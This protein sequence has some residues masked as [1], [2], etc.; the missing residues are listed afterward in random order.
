MNNKCI[1]IKVFKM[2]FLLII[3][4]ITTVVTYKVRLIE[5]CFILKCELVLYKHFRIL[6]IGLNMKHP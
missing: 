4:I 6:D 3:A 5:I 1:F 2:A